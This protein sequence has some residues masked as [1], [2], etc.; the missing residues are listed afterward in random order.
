MLM[1]C[2]QQEPQIASETIVGAATSTSALIGTASYNTCTE[3]E[4][5]VLPLVTFI[6]RTAA[7]SDAFEQCVR[8]RM[9]NYVAS[10]DDAVFPLAD[11]TDKA[12]EALRNVN[13]LRISCTDLMGLRRL[14]QA[15]GGT[16]GAYEIDDF[17]F[18]WIFRRDAERIA[19]YETSSSESRSL[20]RSFIV[21][22]SAATVHEIAH[23]HDYFHDGAPGSSSYDNS[24]PNIAFQCVSEATAN[25]PIFNEGPSTKGLC[26]MD[27]PNGEDLQSCIDRCVEDG[28]LLLSG[29]RTPLLRER[30]YDPL[31]GGWGLF[32]FS[33]QMPLTEALAPYGQ[34]ISPSNWSTQ[35][36]D[37]VLATDD[38]DGVDGDELLV[39][40]G[41]GVYVLSVVP[42]PA[43]ETRQFRMRTSAHS[44]R[45][46]LSTERLRLGI[47]ALLA[48]RSSCWLRTV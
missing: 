3:A 6:A 42:G 39:Q 40:R 12:L 25:L 31:F 23:Q 20:L 47:L 13:P 9:V 27:C 18:S 43:G 21:T 44:G 2:G 1:G 35:P 10:R 8:A 28:K 11:R 41:T 16:H 45:I 17:Q 22:N 19:Q 26:D 38:F 24:V 30:V 46:V 29:G 32:S 34:V 15:G 5:A 14:A 33:G 7:V 37:D 36:T 48:P 4:S